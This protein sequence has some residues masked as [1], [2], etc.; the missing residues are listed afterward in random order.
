MSDGAEIPAART[1]LVACLQ[2]LIAAMDTVDPA[3]A[4]DAQAH[5]SAAFPFDG[6]AVTH[7]FA[8][9][10]QGLA[11]GWLVPHEA[12]PHVRF[13]RLDKDMGGY[14]VDC[15]LNDEHPMY[16]V[17]GALG[18]TC[19]EVIDAMYRSNKEGKTITGEW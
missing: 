19:L 15:V 2:P 10:E 3:A 13:G 16:G 11:D 12:G 8:L 14:A 1:E 6:E 4:E 7:I 18:L 17:S 9:C 5:L